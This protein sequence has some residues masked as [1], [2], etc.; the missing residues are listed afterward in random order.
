M[1]DEVER[2]IRRAVIDDDQLNLAVV[3]RGHALERRA[4][5]FLAVV[6]RHDDGEQNTHPTIRAGRATS[7]CFAM[8][9]RY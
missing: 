5:E 1:A 6:R 8:A 9:A 3:L 7:R 2:A 4:K